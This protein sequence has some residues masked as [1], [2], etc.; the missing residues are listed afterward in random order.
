MNLSRFDLR[1]MG[2]KQP[3]F[4]NPSGDKEQLKKQRESNMRCELVIISAES[5]LP[6]DFDADD[7]K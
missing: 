6:S 4:A 5:E 2:F 3:L 1:G 7:L